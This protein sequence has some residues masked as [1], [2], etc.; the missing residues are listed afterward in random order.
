[1]QQSSIS[2]TATRT[3]TIARSTRRFVALDSLRGVC[4]ILV[5]VHN[6]EYP[7]NSFVL[8]SSL[9]VDFFFV[10]SG[11][12]IT[13][14][15]MSRLATGSEFSAFI[16]RRLGRLWP[17]HVTMLIAFVCLDIIKFAAASLTHANFPVPPFAP[18][19]S[20]I[21]IVSNLLLVQAVGIHTEVSWNA[22]SW[23][24]STEFWTYILFAFLCISSRGRPPSVAIMATLALSA[25][26]IILLL[27]P[28]YLETNT[29]YAMARCIYGFFVGHTVYR[30]IEMKK[31]KIS[32]GSTLEAMAVL[33]VFAFVWISEGVVSIAAPIVF[34]CAVWVFA[35][36]S[37]HISKLLRTSPL[38]YLGDWSYSIY[39]VHWLIRNSIF[40][41]VK[42]AM[43]LTGIRSATIHMPCDERSC[44]WTMGALLI[45][46]LIAVIIVA[47]VTFK[48]IEQPSRRYFNQIAKNLRQNAL[49]NRP[50]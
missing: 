20:P 25:A 5:A 50:A 17:L 22:P 26:I 48:L 30:A 4:A 15:Y 7:Q 13:H 1:M 24:I 31:W 47:S 18:P 28:S 40:V 43:M 23:S 9:F 33:L 41:A 46:Y 44:T 21:A 14:A 37:G 36:E 38:V 45:G 42:F 19:N 27:S 8:H 6:F 12:V 32:V 29:D 35:Q 11:F 49:A 16:V 10:L 2:K 3:H 39:M 34:G